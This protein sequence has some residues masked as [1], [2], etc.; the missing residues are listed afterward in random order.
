[1]DELID[2]T[3]KMHGS[4]A[5]ILLLMAIFN[6]FFIDKNF[7]VKVIKKRVRMILPA[8]YLVLSLILFT[9]LVLLGAVQFTN[10]YSLV[11]LV[12]IIA[13]LF[14]LVM[15][16]KSYKKMKFLQ[17]EEIESYIIFYK[18]KYILDTIILFVVMGLGY[19]LGN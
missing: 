2:L 1:V 7:E 17:K 6:Y 13:W 15:S 9:G 5:G 10:L 11:V 4:F 12:M 14:I 16:I 3:L 19:S 18:K 8:Y